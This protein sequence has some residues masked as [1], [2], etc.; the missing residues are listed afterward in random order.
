MSV[1]IKTSK[2]NVSVDTTD[3]GKLGLT[4]E[5][6]ALKTFTFGSGLVTAVSS[7]GS[8]T[9]THGLGYV[10][11]VLVYIEDEPGSNRRYLLT[12]VSDSEATG[13]PAWK[14]DVDE[15][16]LTVTRTGTFG[17]DGVYNF[18]YYIFYDQT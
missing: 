6:P 14:L 8:E 3:L 5:Y 9:I 17:G 15:N 4:S 7:T 1:G 12:S 2:K 11:L 10:P 13:D 16:N 18:F